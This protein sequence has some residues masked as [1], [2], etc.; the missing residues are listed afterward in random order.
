MK[1]ENNIAWICL[2]LAGLLE[3]V[4]GY[5]LKAS[6]GFSRPGPAIAAI[7]FI[8]ISF[9]L[10]ERAVRKFGIGLSY[11]VFT[12]L[13]IVGTSLLGMAALGESIS[14][15]KVLALIVLMTGIVGIKF[16]EGKEEVV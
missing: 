9:F 15:L 3:T 4:W 2:I 11:G 7:I 14:L 5:F 10:L 8:A 6:Q 12:G 1:K 13:G 16:C